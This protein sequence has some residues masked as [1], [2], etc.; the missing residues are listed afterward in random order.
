MRFPR[1]GKR[2][3]NPRRTW[4]FPLKMNAAKVPNPRARPWL[5]RWGATT[6]RVGCRCAGLSGFAFLAGASAQSVLA[7]PPLDFSGTNQNPQLQQGRLAGTSVLSAPP[8]APVPEEP[9]LRWGPVDFHPHFLYRFLYGDGIPAQANEKITTA[10]H[11]VYPGILFQVGNHWQLDYTPS[12]HYYSNSRFR[13][14]TDQSVALNGAT[15]YQNWTLGLAQRYATT[16][17][18]LIETGVQT[19]MEMYNTALS[20]AYHLNSKASLEVALSQDFQSVGQSSPS[21]LD[22]KQWSTMDW[23]NY[24]FW[25][26]LGAALGVGA[27]Y[28]DVSVGSAMSFEQLQGRISWLVADKLSAQVSGGFDDRQFLD[29]NEP[30][31]ISPLFAASIIYQ[32][33]EATTVSLSAARSVM[34]SYVIEFGQVVENT[35]INGR[36]Q[37]RLFKKL[38]F[39]LTGGYRI[40]SYQASFL[41]LALNRED[42]YTYVNVRLSV[43]FF[44]RGTAGVFYQ[45][46]DNTSTPSAASRFDLSSK[47]V[48]FDLGYR[49]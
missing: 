11:E 33:F 36:F 49:F 22:Y 1:L 34:N 16:S 9:L 38:L 48:G 35:E 29:V 18:P 28:V 15:T 31:S 19:D 5:P 24:Q 2:L 32:A 43:P 27:G 20:A 39:D 26:K 3:D 21:T 13:D 6:L 42:H 40:M 46:G 45:A 25:P 47:Q 8:E 7:P 44:K 10:I 14:T 4:Y 12:L 23:L 30:D 41:G 17:Q 37:Q